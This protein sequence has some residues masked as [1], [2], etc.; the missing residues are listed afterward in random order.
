VKA[1]RGLF[2]V[3]VLVHAAPAQERTAAGERFFDDRVEPVLRTH[4]LSCHNDQL[5]SGGVS[6][7]TRENLLKGGRNGPAVVPGNPQKS[8]LIAAVRQEGDLKMPPGAKLPAQDIAT[9]TAWIERGAS[10]GAKK[11]TAD[12]PA[13]LR[14]FELWIFDRL[15]EIGGHRPKILGNPRVID[16]PLGKA[17]EF[18][19]VDDAL[20]LEIHPLAEAGP[21]T[22]EV[23]FRPD[24]GGRPEQRFFHM[25]E[26]DASGKDTANRLLFET[27]LTGSNWYLDTFALS[28]AVSKALL[29]R[30]HLHPLDAWYHAAM[31]Y[32]GR[33]MRNYVNGVLENSGEIT[34]APHAAGHTSVGVRIN[35]VDYFKGAIR[36]SRMTRAA[37][38]PTEFIKLEQLSGGK[39]P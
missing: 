21:F 7:T 4:C 33:E 35:L 11:L 22:W 10:W 14:P 3:A 38:S 20:F 30:E 23:V 5:R 16:S 18:D 36:L 25:Q 37:L 9:L 12:E 26:R 24:S 27:R 1:A 39:L 13:P 2:L 31:V 15:E 17:I 8:A 19:G 6:F 29:N 28:G 34:L 32:D